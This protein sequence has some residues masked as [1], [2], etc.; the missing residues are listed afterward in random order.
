VLKERL[1][2]QANAAYEARSFG[3]DRGP[4]LHSSKARPDAQGFVRLSPPFSPVF[5]V[6][7]QLLWSC[8]HVLWSWCLATGCSYPTAVPPTWLSGTWT[9]R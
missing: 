6:Q 8:T 2:A 9:R 3:G 5:I 1:K 7:T 4:L